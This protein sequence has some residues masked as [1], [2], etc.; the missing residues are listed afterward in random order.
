MELRAQHGD[1]RAPVFVF[2]PLRTPWCR[3]GECCALTSGATVASCVDPTELY[4]AGRTSKSRKDGDIDAFTDIDASTG[5]PER[6]E[7]GNR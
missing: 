4:I 1:A 3:R 7:G 6:G 5:S 2:S